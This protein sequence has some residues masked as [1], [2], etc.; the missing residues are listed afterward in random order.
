MEQ[1]KGSP[2][3]VPATAQI[4]LLCAQ[5]IAD[6][7]LQQIA[8]IGGSALG[9]LPTHLRSWPLDRSLVMAEREQADRIFM[10]RRPRGVNVRICRGE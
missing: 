3:G 9:Y 10:H 7:G 2:K 6:Q 1:L 4:T 5:P 8:Q